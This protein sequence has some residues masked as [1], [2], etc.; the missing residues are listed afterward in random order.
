MFYK[1]W[2]FIFSRD[3]GKLQGKKRVWKTVQ[4]RRQAALNVLRARAAPWSCM[5]EAA[6]KCPNSTENRSSWLARYRCE[7]ERWAKSLGIR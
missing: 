6:G 2:F 7:H 4:E 5:V 3:G 1:K